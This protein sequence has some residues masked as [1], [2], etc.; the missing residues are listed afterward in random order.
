M[1]SSDAVGSLL[2]ALTVKVEQCREK[3]SACGQEVGNALYGL[4][5]MGSNAEV[6]SLLHALSVKVERC[7]KELSG[8]AV[9][10]GNAVWSAG[11]GQQCISRFWVEN[12]AWKH[13]KNMFVF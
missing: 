4:Q 7:T 10:V 8:Q 2:L 3:L 5:G 11:D 12:P 9:L 6:D 13:R 1:Q